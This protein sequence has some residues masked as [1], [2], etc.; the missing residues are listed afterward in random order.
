MK[1]KAFYNSLKITWN[2][3]K[4]R[5]PVL[6]NLVVA[7]MVDSNGFMDIMYWGFMFESNQVSKEFG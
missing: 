6:K 7:W 2:F 1:K 4:Q 3:S 5:N